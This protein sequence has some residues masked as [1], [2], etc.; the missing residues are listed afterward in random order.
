[1]GMWWSHS[2]LPTYLVRSDARQFLG[3]YHH[4]RDG[5]RVTRLNGICSHSW[6][7]IVLE[8]PD[9]P[10]QGSPHQLS[11][12]QQPPRARPFTA[13]KEGSLAR[14]SLAMVSN[15]PSSIPFQ[16]HPRAEPPFHPH[17]RGAGAGKQSQVSTSRSWQGSC[18][19]TSFGVGQRGLCKR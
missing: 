1:M 10:S 16:F 15:I 11:H 13:K 9:L 7:P 6:F 8:L 19:F 12:S 18:G 2:S 4:G 14:C 5:N 3:C 17:S